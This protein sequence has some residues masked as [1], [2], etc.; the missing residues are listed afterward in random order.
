MFKKRRKKTQA[1]KIMQLISLFYSLVTNSHQN[2]YNCRMW[3]ACAYAECNC[4]YNCYLTRCPSAFSHQASGILGM[5]C[6]SCLPRPVLGDPLTEFCL[7]RPVLGDPLT[8]FFR[9]AFAFERVLQ[10]PFPSHLWTTNWSRMR[11]PASQ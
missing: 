5:E 4:N 2:R 11:Y 6:V 10:R 3:A 8:E 1:T 7:P 9:N